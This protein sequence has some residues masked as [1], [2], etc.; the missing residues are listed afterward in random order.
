MK[1]SMYEVIEI[2]RS[3][4]GIRANVA[5][6]ILLLSLIAIPSRVLQHARLIQRLNFIII[7]FIVKITIKTL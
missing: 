5:V 2:F 7:V 3:P 4:G 6:K 1:Y